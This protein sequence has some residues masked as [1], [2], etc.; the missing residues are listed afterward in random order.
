MG[1]LDRISEDPRVR[2]RNQAGLP[3]TGR[4]VLYWMQR[5]H[6]AEGNPA[7][8]TAVAAAR[9]LELPLVVLFQLVPDFP[10]ATERHYAFLLEGLEETA[11]SLEARGIPFRLRLHEG[12]PADGVAAFA[13][14]AAT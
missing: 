3:E 12:D 13:D 6:R 7:L 2:H 14:E 4:C 5:A 1:W 10:G 9:A 11:R 8:E